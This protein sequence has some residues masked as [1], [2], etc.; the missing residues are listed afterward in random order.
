MAAL[1][2][3]STSDIR[4]DGLEVDAGLSAA[5]LSSKLDQSEVA[6]VDGNDNVGR[7]T[8]R[9]SRSGVD[10]VV[11]ARVRVTVAVPCVRCLE[12]AVVQ[13]DEMLSLLLQPMSRGSK[14]ASKQQAGSAEYEFSQAEA[15]FD[16]YDGETVELDD[17]VRE[18]ILLEVPS[19]PLCR[20]DCPGIE[21]SGQVEPEPTGFD[22]R[23]APLSA[24]KKD[25]EG[26]VTIA[27]LVTAARERSTA[28]GRK[29]KLGTSH[30][31]KGKRKK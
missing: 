31:G 4:L 18:L 23:L 14:R 28:L 17:F 19:F 6:P 26:P 27:D 16:V 7:V 9:L 5:W 13:V 11:R 21:P 1:L 15:D 20:E 29:P 3:F 25:K 10:I 22:P 2:T 30:R 24:F 12:A 8:G